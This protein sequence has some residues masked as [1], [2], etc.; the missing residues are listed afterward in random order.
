MEEEDFVNALLLT[1][2]TSYK[3]GNLTITI[4]GKEREVIDKVIED[5]GRT[6]NFLQ[7]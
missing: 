1:E 4:D 5:K 7:E 6:R 3:I 2:K